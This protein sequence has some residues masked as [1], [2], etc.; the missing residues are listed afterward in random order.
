MPKPTTDIPSGAS[1]VAAI[2]RVTQQQ[3]AAF[4]AA[5]QLALVQSPRRDREG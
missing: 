4:M 2:R 5:L 1:V 3:E